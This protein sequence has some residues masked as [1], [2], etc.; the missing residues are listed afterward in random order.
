[1]FAQNL[2]ESVIKRLSIEAKRLGA[3]NFGQGIPP[4]PTAPHIIAAAKAALDES[5]IGVYPN[6][7]GSLELREAIGKKLSVDPAKNILITVGA[8]EGTATAIL[9]IVQNGDR[10]G[11]ITP[12]YCNHF[13][14]I[15]LARGIIVEIPMI[16][17]ARWEID[18]AAV[19][20]EAKVG[21]RL[22][23]LTN[24]NNPT[25][26]VINREELKQL[27]A[28]AKKYGFWMLSDETYSFLTY[29]EKAV[30]LLEFWNE[31]ERL[32]VVRS[33]SKEYA[34]TG[35]RV[36]YILA[37]A[38]TLSVFAKTHDALVGCVPK[39]SQIAAHAAITGPQT[40][41]E[42]YRTHYGK[43]RRIALDAF[44][45]IKGISFAVPQGAYYIFFKS[46]ISAEQI[47][48]VA[49]VALVPGL[50]FGKAGEGHLRLSF[51]ADEKVLLEGLGR[52]AT[53]GSAFRG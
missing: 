25:G 32:I 22:L 26:A 43:L 23:I 36:G 21:L 30:S 42:E 40:I 44:A 17:K 29:G 13:P 47:L 28:L 27:V 14:E 49:N 7:L 5:D 39:I 6:F 46:A 50:V 1:M 34:M 38:Q 3:I 18:L 24:P 2:P 53:K 33:F 19:E 41:V 11:V 20:R 51:A 8:M 45:D 12:D 15:Q 9:S 10:V 4:F 31:Y 48:K 16:E 37:E 35:W 52:L